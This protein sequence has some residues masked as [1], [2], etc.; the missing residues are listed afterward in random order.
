M[1]LTFRALSLESGERGLLR[2]RVGLSS[3]SSKLSTGG[4]L[5]TQLSFERRTRRPLRTGDKARLGWAPPKGFEGYGWMGGGGVNG[6]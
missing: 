4:A 5:D 1:I 2:P 3:G 6:T